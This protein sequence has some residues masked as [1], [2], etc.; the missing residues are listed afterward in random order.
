MDVMID[1]VISKFRPN[2]IGSKIVLENLKSKMSQSILTSTSAVIYNN[3]MTFLKTFD[4]TKVSRQLFLNEYRAYKKI[5]KI[6]AMTQYVPKLI[7]SSEN[8]NYGV[9]NPF[10]LIENTGM[11]GIE[12]MNNVGISFSIWKRFVVDMSS[13]I[14]LLHENKI[15]HCDIKPENTTYSKTLNKWTLIDFGF[16]CRTRNGNR[17]FGTMPYCSPHYRNHVINA[18]TTALT[19]GNL[20]HIDDIYAFAMSSLSLFGYYYNNIIDN[21]KIQ[22]NIISLIRLYNG[23][24]CC[25]DKK[26]VPTNVVFDYQTKLIIKLLS[27]IILTQVNV[28]SAVLEWDKRSLTCI[29][30]GQHNIP[31]DVG[32]DITKYWKELNIIIKNYNK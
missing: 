6:K 19:S 25:L 13:A 8:Y 15:T 20:L 31:C 24:M 12:Y 3:D 1:S 22:F 28:H 18:R 10:L 21:D 16:S 5:E 26:Y 9:N 29:F 27:S 23:D 2:K 11:D 32:Y 17:F 4:K 7:D 30:T 14:S